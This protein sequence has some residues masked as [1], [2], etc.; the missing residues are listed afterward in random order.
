MVDHFIVSVE[1]PDFCVLLRA[2]SL[3]ATVLCASFFLR[4]SSAQTPS[5]PV[6]LI[7]SMNFEG[8]RAQEVSTP[9]IN[10]VIVPQLCARVMQ[11][12]FLGHAD[13][14]G[15]PAFIGQYP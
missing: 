14:Y 3:V 6:C 1:A 13:L 11:V 15:D 2:F 4:Q 12:T 10:V 7:E 8:W 5:S 9:W